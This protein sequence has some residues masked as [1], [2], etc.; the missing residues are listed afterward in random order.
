MLLRGFLHLTGLSGPRLSPGA[1]QLRLPL[2]CFARNCQPSM[3]GRNRLGATVAGQLHVAGA[4]MQ[5]FLKSSESE[6][7]HRQGV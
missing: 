7:L 4:V 3:T 6:D 1:A 2:S 5:A